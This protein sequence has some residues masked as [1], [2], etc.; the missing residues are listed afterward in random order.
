ML[1][2]TLYD[3]TGDLADIDTMLVNRK[4]LK[5]LMDDAELGAVAMK[6]VDRA[7][8]VHPGIDDAE[9]ICADFYEAMVAMLD[10]VPPLKHIE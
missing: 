4:D 7:G 5:R 3:I 10:S 1:E 9:T 2:R 6:F 8:D